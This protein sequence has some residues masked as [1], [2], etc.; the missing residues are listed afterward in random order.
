MTT[1]S[2]VQEMAAEGK[3]T[4]VIRAHLTIEGMA[5]KDI[6]ALLKDAGVGRQTAGFTQQN[7]LALLEGGVSEFELYS[8]VL[9]NEAKNEA[10][11]ISDRNKI[12]ITLNRIYEKLGSPVTEKPATE[13]QK[14]AIK[15]LK[16]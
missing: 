3:S 6:S 5:D 12:R 15:V 8:A 16:G 11:W 1:I 13:K 10:R 4:K 2:K 14:A 9:E 7:T